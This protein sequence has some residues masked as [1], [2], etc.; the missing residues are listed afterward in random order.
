MDLPKGVLDNIAGFLDVRSIGETAPVARLTEYGVT[1]N[2]ILGERIRQHVKNVRSSDPGSR[3][4]EDDLIS[5]RQLVESTGFV[6]PSVAQRAS[7]M[8]LIASRW[9]EHNQFFPIDVELEDGEVITVD[10][11]FDPRAIADEVFRPIEWNPF[12]ATVN[13]WVHRYYVR[14]VGGARDAEERDGVAAPLRDRRRLLIAL[15]AKLLLMLLGGFLPGTYA[16]GSDQGSST[17]KY[18]AL[19]ALVVGWLTA[20]GEAIYVI[21]NHVFM[22]LTP[23]SWYY[24]MVPEAQAA[25]DMTV[26]VFAILLFFH[27]WG[28]WS[29][30]MGLAPPPQKHGIDRYLGQLVTEKGLVHRVQIGGREY[31]LSANPEVFGYH[32]DEMAMPGSEYFPCKDQPIGAILVNTATSDLQLFGTFWRMDDFFVTARHC[33]NTLNQ[34]TATAYLAP[35]RKTKRG[36]YEIDRSNVVRLGDGFFDPANNMIASYDID[37]F[38]CELDK[39]LWSQIQVKASTT[40]VRSAYNQQVHT[41]GFTAD[42]LLVSA[43]GK[44]LGGSGYEFLHH[45]AS[46]QKGFS[47][48]ILLCGNSV[49][50]MH[51]SAAGEHNVAI[52]VELIQYL[53][54]RGSG[55]EA[56]SKN[57]KRY[58]YAD[59]SYKEQY[60]QHKWRGAVTTLK[61]M[62]D[63]RYAVVLENGEATYGWSMDELVTCF[64]ITGN[65]MKDEDLMHDLLMDNYPA[66][67]R[68]QYIDYDD[69]RYHR[70]SYEN[71]SVGGLSVSR[72]NRKKPARNGVKAP[73]LPTVNS[74]AWLFEVQEGLKPVHGPTAPKPQPEALNMIAAHEEEIVSYGY[75]AGLFSYPEMTPAE[76]KNSLLKH[77]RKFGECVK[78]VKIAPTKEEIQRCATIVAS[79][80]SANAFVPDANYDQVEGV[81]DII[82]SSIID[83]SK[84][85]GYP[86]CA[87]GKPTNKL[88]L[89][90]F[91]EKGFAQHVINEWNEPLVF[92]V[93]EKG[94][95]TKRKKLDAGMPRIITGFPLHATVKHAAILK[96]FAFSLVKN[97]KRSP[98]KYAFSPA[99]PGH[100]EHLKTVFPGEV[101]DSDKGT[102]DFS[103]LEWVVEV[104]CLV[105]QYLANRHPD[106]D[107]ERFAKY[108]QDVRGM[109]DQVFKESQYRCSDGTLVKVLVKGIMKS[110]FF[111]TIA[112]NSVAQLA[113]HVMVCMRLGLND[114]EIEGIPIIAGGDDVKQDPAGLDQEQ[115]TMAAADLGVHMEIEPKACLEE[116]EYFSNDIRKGKEGLEFYPQR[117]TK[118]IEH[119]K[120]IKL[121]HLPDALCSHMEN[122]RHDANKFRL[123]ENMYHTMRGSHP[124]T[125][126]VEKLKSRQYLLAKQYGYE[127][128]L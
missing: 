62:R 94:E 26:T 9:T 39:G 57:R 111:G 119:L 128:A 2:E 71:A 49:I 18:A 35:T 127:H 70:N 51:V 15:K 121:E 106:W 108:K 86:Y 10:Q 52:R 21:A 68:H 66:A 46:T 83:P 82:Q 44:T 117:W 45:T 36:N 87:E 75:D 53:I 59:A 30:E 48:S 61:T 91:G 105:V 99:Q 12:G 80:M 24:S 11:P 109:F 73:A 47:G 55:L 77:L 40:N 123:L 107:E 115:Y 74:D 16:A 42:G 28:Q 64:G 7:L 65:T 98:V 19:W 41:V 63:G 79:M 122:Y 56:V 32:E 88:V 78:S 113:I 58:T 92:K 14:P 20:V 124:D 34:S 67:R 69:D 1:E 93:F 13:P 50:G 102:W 85:S 120:T 126:P 54:D 116:S 17:N 29:A 38:A 23:R 100:L 4:R 97:F 8:E 125:F 112:V 89:E 37:A 110:G 43:S 95:P 103:F 101:W 72:R 96:N 84:S 6:A 22:R 60:R 118:H 76:E 25:L 104:C 3:F 90:Q 5:R 33:S 81:Y 114:D 31:T 27:L